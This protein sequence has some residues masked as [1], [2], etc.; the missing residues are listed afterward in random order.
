MSRETKPHYWRGR[1]IGDAELEK[2]VE[3]LGAMSAGIEPLPTDVVLDSCDH[4]SRALSDQGSDVRLRLEKAAGGSKAESAPAFAEIARQL[5]RASLETKLKRE[6]GSTRPFLLSR[7]SHDEDLFEAWMPLGL[8]VHVS[9]QNSFATGAM[10]VV[11]GLLS[12]NVNFL[13]TGA[14]EPPFAQ[15]FLEALAES[16]STGVLRDHVIAA[17]ISS[18]RKDLLARVFSAADGI[19]AWG[20]EDSV[21]SI[22][23]MAPSGARLIEWGHRI[24]FIYLTPESAADPATLERIA[25]ECCHLDQLSCSS[26]QCIYLDSDDDGALERF[27]E[28]LAQ[29]LGRVSAGIPGATP[30]AAAQAEISMVALCQELESCLG[31]ARVIAG[32]DGSWRVLVDPRPALAPSPLYRNVWVKP[33]PR[34][35]IPQVL[36]PMKAYLQTAG[37]A[38]GAKD[39]HELT[40]LLL[41]AG[42][43]RVRR[44]GAMTE[45]YAGEPHDG[46]YPLQRYCRRVSAQAPFD[47][48]GISSFDELTSYP[49][50]TWPAKQPVTPKQ[51]FSDENP[52]AQLFFKSGGS[53]GKPKLSAVTYRQYDDDI[54][55]GAQ[56]FYAAGLDPASDRAMNLFFC[57]GLY[58]GF[59]SVFSALKEIGVV[60]FPMAA[61]TD[62]QAVADA[63]V[64]HRVDTLLGMP[65]YLMSLFEKN[66]EAFE[67]YHGV[68]KIFYGGEHFTSAQRHY[69]KERFGVTLIRSG[70]YGSVDI[71][72]MGYQ[73]GHCEDGVHHLQQRLHSLEILK[74]DGDRPAKDGEA[75]RLVFSPRNP[76]STKP[77]RYDI[78]DVG[79][80]IGGRGEPCP[81]GRLAPRFKL[82][83]RTGDIFRIGAVFLNYRTFAE[84]LSDRARYA[85]DLQIR[86]VE[87]NLR[88]KVVLRISQGAGLSARDCAR[89]CLE[90]YGDLAEAVLKDKTLLFDAVEIRAED[91]ER[92]PASG[93]L[94]SVVDGR[95]R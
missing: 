94:L 40:R 59:I 56:G 72:P 77:R 18:K 69:L 4:L 7:I 3:T 30:D 39:V 75:G 37:L 79:H 88:E 63:V 53:S 90:H 1:W 20:G 27:A 51:S 65:S 55:L 5:S 15:L 17:R 28:G 47:A 83:G 54:E 71:G 87:E 58:G 70:A 46:L 14:A 84:L 64:S 23:R 9:P 82:L 32:P 48:G 22:R 81:C 78:G 73:C 16:D 95:S 41:A 2:H 21:A 35:K 66:A 80:W 60:Q 34:R 62:F 91:F 50:L 43:T 42:A 29:A 19:A 12:G 85:G 44:V 13:K 38:C 6:L 92:S 26:P 31:H 24:S 8:L 61:Q 76:G 10:S 49:P 89:L 57:G 74:L 52:K 33:L 86:L 25:S 45:S 67:R 68:K 93:K 36:R 11:E